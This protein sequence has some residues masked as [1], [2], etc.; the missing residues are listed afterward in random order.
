LNLHGGSRSLQAPE[1]G[2]PKEMFRCW[3]NQVL[4]AC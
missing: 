1:P 4:F 2:T 3:I